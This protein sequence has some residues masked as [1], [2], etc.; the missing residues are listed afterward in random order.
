[1]AY[2]VPKSKQTYIQYQNLI[3]TYIQSDSGEVNYERKPSHGG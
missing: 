1:M 3:K 2:V